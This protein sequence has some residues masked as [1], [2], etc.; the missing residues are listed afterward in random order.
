[1]KL[2]ICTYAGISAPVT[3]VPNRTNEQHALGPE[4]L[5]QHA[6]PQAYICIE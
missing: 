6:Q 2:F 4:G 3:Y 5:A 1:M